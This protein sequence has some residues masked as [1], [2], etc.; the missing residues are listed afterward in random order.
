[1]VSDNLTDARLRE[2][3]FGPELAYVCSCKN[4]PECSIRQTVLDTWI[5]LRDTA[6]AEGAAS[7]WDAV[8]SLAASGTPREGI[9]HI[10]RANAA[11]IR[12]G[13]KG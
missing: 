1:M 10:A 13:E 8:A 3:A 7:A 5:A 12:A 11:V 9:E 6:Y 2:R 4:D